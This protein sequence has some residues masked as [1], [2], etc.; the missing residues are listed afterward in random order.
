MSKNSRDYISVI[1]G[2]IRKTANAS[3]NVET[4]EASSVAGGMSAGKPVYEQ[5]KPEERILQKLKIELSNPETCPGCLLKG[6]KSAH[7]RE[8][9][10]FIFVAAQVTITKI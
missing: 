9:C 10:K 5:W 7:H 6:F 3:G 8:I 1:M 2:R 4:K